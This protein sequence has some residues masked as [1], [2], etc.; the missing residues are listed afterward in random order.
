MLSKN[1]IKLINSLNVKKYRHIHKLFVA[2]GEKM[3]GDIVKMG[4]PVKTIITTIPLEFGALDIEVIRCLP[5][6]LDK[7]SFMMNNQGVLAL[8]EIQEKE[9]STDSLTG[10]LSIGLD[11]VQDPGNFGT[12]VRLANWFGINKILCSLDCVDMYNPKVVQASMGAILGVDIHY[13][14]LAGYLDVLSEREGFEIYG[15]FMDAEPVFG[16][17]LSANG[18]LVLGNE[19]KGISDNVSQ[20][21][22]QKIAIPSCHQSGFKAESLN[23]GV[24]AG[25][26]IAE[27]YRQTGYKK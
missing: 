16:Q 3:V 18:I 4:A 27:F 19:G 24:A 26:I 22:K 1:L 25:I 8:V 12:I 13:V 9:L 10:H 14:D 20:K 23:V 15:T 11:S 2:E 6:E 5:F 17:T 7:L 21:I